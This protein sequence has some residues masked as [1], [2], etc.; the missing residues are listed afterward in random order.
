MRS[1]LV[2]WRWGEGYS[3]D[4]NVNH[5]S[6]CVCVYFVRLFMPM[7]ISLKEDNALREFEVSNYQRIFLASDDL[8]EK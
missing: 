7:C 3:Q 5:V 1:G 6:V 2:D 4:L 8:E